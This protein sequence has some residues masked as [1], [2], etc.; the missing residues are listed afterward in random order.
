M[1]ASSGKELL[2]IER[3]KKERSLFE[4]L[5]EFQEF[6]IVLVEGFKSAH[7]PW[8]VVFD[9]EITRYDI[10]LLQEREIIGLVIQGLSQIG[11]YRKTLRRRCNKKKWRGRYKNYSRR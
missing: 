3:S 9:N 8:I 2:K 4:I 7:I 1:V 5:K 6:E 11:D 10:T